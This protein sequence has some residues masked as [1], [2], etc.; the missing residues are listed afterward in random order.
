M[1]NA[2]D[3]LKTSIGS[4]ELDYCIYNASGPK[5]TTLDELLTLRDSNYTGAVLT[6]SCTLNARNGNDPPKYF[7]NQLGSLNSNGLENLGHRFYADIAPNMTSKTKP[8][9]ISIAGLTYEDN[10]QILLNLTNHSQIEYISSI[11]LNLS[12]PNILGKSQVG[13][14]FES[15]E[16]YLDLIS[17]IWPKK[18]GVKL[19][20]YFDMQHF[21]QA[22]TILN[23][24]P[25]LQYVTC[26]NSLGNALIIDGVTESV[27]IHPKNGFG[28][29][30]GIYIKPT[31]L[32]NVRQMYLLL[33]PGI[34]IIGVGGI[35]TGMD[36]FEHILCGAKAVQIGTQLYEEGV[37]C[38]ERIATELL[39]IMDRKGYRHIEDF[40]GNLNL[41]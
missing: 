23:K 24:Y 14:D 17:D 16:K 27:T 41:I 32:A 4:I 12:C 11:E 6:K 20:P 7:A 37:G 13:Y 5:C 8:Y 33:R 34:D 2:Y 19:P 35:T 36:A 28:G 22:A 21:Q 39:E 10:K 30:G 40:R 9:I 1:L 15:M 38:F 18:F 29:L 25:E 26:I 3:A 31:A